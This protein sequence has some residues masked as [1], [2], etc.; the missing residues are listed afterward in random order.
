[1][2][3]DPIQ[4]VDDRVLD[5]AAAHIHDLDPILIHDRKIVDH[6]QEVNQNQ[7]WFQPYANHVLR[8]DGRLPFH[9][10]NLEANQNVHGPEHLPEIIQNGDRTADQE[11]DIVLTKNLEVLILKVDLEVIRRNG[12]QEVVPRFDDLI[13]VLRIVVL[14]VDQ[15]AGDL[16][17]IQVGQ[18]QQLL[19]QHQNPLS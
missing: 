6:V 8:Q 11:V 19:H 15:M 2:S 7:S 1:M 14:E 17:I 5:L 16:N 9:V 18:I 4:E 13:V 12:N 10:V 3:S